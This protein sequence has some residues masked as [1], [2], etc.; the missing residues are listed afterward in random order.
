[1]KSLVYVVKSSTNAE[2]LNRIMDAS[3]HI[4]SD[5]PSLIRAVTKDHNVHNQGGHFEQ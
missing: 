3:E 4:K 1:M 5:K 2:Q